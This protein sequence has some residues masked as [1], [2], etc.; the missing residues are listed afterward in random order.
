MMSFEDVLPS[1]TPRYKY[2]NGGIDEC[3]RVMGQEVDR[4]ERESSGG[5]SNPY[6]IMDID[7]PSY[8]ECFINSGEGLLLLSSEV[9]NHASQ[10]TIVEVGSPTHATAV[11]ALNEI[12]L[13]WH[14]F[15][16]TSIVNLGTAGFRGE[17]ISKKGAMSWVPEDPSSGELQDWPSLVCE[18]AWSVPRRKL[19]Q[20]IEFWFKESKGQVKVVI[21]MTVHA[22]GRISIEQWG[23]NQ[24]PDG[25]MDLRIPAQRI[26]IVR[27]PAP[28]CPRVSGE[29]K[30]KFRDV[31]LREKKET[32][33]DFV[34]TEKSMEL[35]ALQ[36][37][38][39]QFREASP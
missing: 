23:R 21:A 17:T 27:K 19:L 5:T 14:S 16:D 30:L 37:W 24:R 7:E 10:S 38:N 8:L 9:Y 26:E 20:D 29:L 39:V 4:Y 36:V 12:F 1:T 15:D 31:Y 22:R 6:F 11:S 33:K 32:D 34:V 2:N 3:V 25:S 13:A 35:L 18:V 28:N